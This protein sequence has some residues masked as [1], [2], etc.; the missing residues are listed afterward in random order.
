MSVQRFEPSDPR[1]WL[2]RARGNLER[3]VLRSEHS[4]FED[5]CFDAQQAAEKAIKAVL[6]HRA[7]DFPYVHDLDKLLG[8]IEGS[9]LQIPD[10]VRRAGKLTRY[11][12]ATRYP[13]FADEVTENDHSGAVEI[14]TAGLAS[15]EPPGPGSRPGPAAAPRKNTLRPL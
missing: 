2:N 5:L 11:A 3:A 6:L 7:V 8:T 10:D 15:L 4:Y 12:V 13:G 1:E 9:G 14:A